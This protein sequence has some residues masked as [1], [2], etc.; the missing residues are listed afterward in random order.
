MLE[1]G[2]PLKLI[3]YIIVLLIAAMYIIAPRFMWRRF[4]IFRTADNPS[5]GFFLIRRIFGIVAVLIV[6]LLQV[7]PYLNNVN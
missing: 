2:N 7:I 6:I 5:D 1:S 4:E 3:G